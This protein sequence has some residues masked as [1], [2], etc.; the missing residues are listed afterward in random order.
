MK[1]S[2]CCLREAHCMLFMMIW[3]LPWMICTLN[4]IPEILHVFRFLYASYS[5][6]SSVKCIDNR[7][8]QCSTRNSK[9]L[10][11][12]HWVFGNPENLDGFPFQLEELRPVEIESLITSMFHW[13]PDCRTS[14]SRYIWHEWWG[15]TIFYA[16]MVWLFDYVYNIIQLVTC[17]TLN[18]VHTTSVY[19]YDCVSTHS[20]DSKLLS[21][22]LI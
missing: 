11:M 7:N 21:S 5:K 2:M 17:D 19:S 10:Y 22:H 18:N 15:P 1:A 13:G 8:Y 3:Y 9:V 20:C 12:L 14:D 6:F 16:N 4:V